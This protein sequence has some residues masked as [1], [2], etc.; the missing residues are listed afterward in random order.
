MHHTPRQS[1]LVWDAPVRVFH[2]LMVLSF[3]G[4]LVTGDSERWR[5]EHITL[6]YTMLG[7]LAFRILWGLVGTRHA[8][9]A[10]FVRGPRRV[11]SYL[12]SLLRGHP[13]HHTGHNPAGAVAIVALLAL[14]AIT[15]I[16]GWAIDAD[17]G[18][19]WLE[20]WHE[21]AANLM[22]AIVV[23]HLLGVLVSSRMHHENLVLGMVTG[24]KPGAPHEA[25]RRTRAVVA[26]GIVA[27]VCA[28]W[29]TQW[30]HAPTAV[31]ANDAPRGASHHDRPPH[32]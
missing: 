3:A 6:G 8:R 10:S 30:Q 16:S 19:H 9:F 25:I 1:I 32:D 15:A 2:W 12:A 4:A 11:A 18:G 24:R 22:L 20:D 5:L 29:W 27:A 26:G 21:G 13:E 17:L 23:V 31:A 7:L 28:F 14:T